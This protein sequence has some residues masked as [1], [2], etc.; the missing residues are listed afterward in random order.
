MATLAQSDIALGRIASGSDLAVADLVESEDN[1]R[2]PQNVYWYFLMNALIVLIGRP[3]SMLGT[4]WLAHAEK[5][6]VQRAEVDG[7]ERIEG[8]VAHTGRDAS[9]CF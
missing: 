1:I 6:G 3:A 7:G 2:I 4:A 5:I 9:A 8:R